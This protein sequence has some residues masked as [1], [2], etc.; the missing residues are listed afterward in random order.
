MNIPRFITEAPLCGTGGS[1]RS[2]SLPV[3]APISLF[4]QLLSAG[5]VIPFST[6]A[7]RA[8]GI[9]ERCLTRLS[10]ATVTVELQSRSADF[11]PN[12]PDSSSNVGRYLP[13][14]SQGHTND[15]DTP[16]LRR[17]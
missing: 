2:G 6:T 9:R 1:Y 7:Y 4:L 17:L 16:N 11:L 15:V 14:L 3:Q 5:T 13:T 12:V 10:V 8:D